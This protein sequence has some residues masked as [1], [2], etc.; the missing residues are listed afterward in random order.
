MSV[1]RIGVSATEK[2]IN[3][4]GLI[5]REQPTD[6]YGIDAQIETIEDGY[7]TGKLIAVQIKSGSSFFDERTGD[8][9]IYRGER[10]HYDYWLNHSL[11]VIIVLYNPTNDTCYWNVVNQK[12]ATKTEKNW[13]IEIPFTNLLIDAKA[14][15]FELADNLT[16]YERKFNTF[17]FAKPWMKEIINGNKVV[18]NVE[19][20][21]NKSSGRGDFKLRIID[22]NGVEKQVFNRSFFGFGLKAYTQVF[23]ELFPWALIMIDSDY[24][25]EFDEEAIDNEDFEAARYTYADSV[26][27]TFDRD[28]FEYNFPENAPS[29]EKWMKDKRNIRPYRIG[30]GEVAFYQLVL[31]L[32]EVA[33]SF[34]VL[35]DFINETTF[36]TFKATPN[37]RR[38]N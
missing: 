28:T 25:T 20:W 33:K 17:L 35:D 9:V 31:E 13:K 24:Y 32:N 38:A 18:L 36:Y 6:D 12:T 5:F 26:G 30:A 3:Q 37:K 23:K 29:I 21:I 2:I 14:Q 10:K 19:E 22:K 34:L 15:L 7:A 16:E 11:P 1:E 8:S 4:M 27:A